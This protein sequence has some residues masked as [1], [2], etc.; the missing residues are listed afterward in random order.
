MGLGGAV[1]T[2]LGAVL[3]TGA[4]VSIGIA[5]GQW[6]DAIIYAI[7]LAGVVALCSG[8]SSAHLAGRYPIAGGTY[9]YGYRTL[10]PY[11][12][13][14]AG[15]L[16]ILAKTASAASAALGFSIYLGLGDPRMIAISATLIMTV[17][18][19]VGLRRTTMV[20]IA[21]ITTTMTGLVAFTWSGLDPAVLG[22]MPPLG[23]DP[24]DILPAVAFLF[25]AYTGYGRVATLGEEVKEP[26]RTIPKAVIVSLG[27]AGL[28]Y[29]GVALAGRTIYGSR[30]G[31]IL[32]TGLTLADLIPPPWSTVVA[33]GAVTA[34]LG[35]LLNLVLGLSR[36]WLAM[37]R[38]GD[39]PR[40]L[41]RL[42]QRSQPAPA[43]WLSGTVVA[44]LCLVGDIGVTWSF[45]AFSVLLYYG[46]TN[47]AA[48]AVD[49]RRWTAWVGLLSCLLLSLYVGLATWLVGTALLATG[50][51]WKRQRRA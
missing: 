26:A 9:E 6:G 17:L 40:A 14:A 46:I 27:I 24:A 51:V 11:W 29:L 4:Y 44:A 12:G 10:G 28:L 35:V 19:A 5:A 31:A 38:R 32:D 36:V 41:A 48:L 15:W 34:M 50:V 21:L 18:V 22:V 42:D 20:N 49:R 16:F 8:L 33:V 7:P 23:A 45:S 3:G 39:M 2:G 1:I 30:W 37:G 13:F 43:V 47:L 25:V